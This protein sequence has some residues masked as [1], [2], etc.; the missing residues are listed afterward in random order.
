M[1]SYPNDTTELS[2][3]S[4]LSKPNIILYVDMLLT[5]SEQYEDGNMLCW[6][7]E[8]KKNWGSTY[9]YLHLQV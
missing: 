7:K 5:L 1:Y 4:L 8:K 2:Q 6:I 9:I 3:I